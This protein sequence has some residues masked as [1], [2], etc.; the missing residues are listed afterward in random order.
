[1][2]GFLYDYD[3]FTPGVHVQNQ[4]ELH[5]ALVK[6]I[7]QENDG[8]KAQRETLSQKLFAYKDAQNAQRIQK[9]ILNAHS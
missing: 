7:T 4:E 5:D 8:F 1:M 2:Q 6:I 3:E 9:E